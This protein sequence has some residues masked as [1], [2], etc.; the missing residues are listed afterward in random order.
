MVLGTS[1]AALPL[2]EDYG[3]IGHRPTQ[4]PNAY[5]QQGRIWPL[6]VY[7]DLTVDQQRPSSILFAPVRSYKESL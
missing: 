5:S 4:F 7:A 1:S 3:R 2:L 6:P